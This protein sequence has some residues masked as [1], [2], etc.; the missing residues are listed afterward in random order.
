[1]LFAFRWD[2]LSKETDA[3]DGKCMGHASETSEEPD[4]QTAS[5]E[6]EPLLL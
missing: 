1:M 6:E 4:S 2:L 5:L 3:V